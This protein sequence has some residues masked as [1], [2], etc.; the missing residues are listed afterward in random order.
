ME[1]TQ[2]E[3]GQIKKDRRQTS[4]LLHLVSK[5]LS[6]IKFYPWLTKYARLYSSRR[7]ARAV[8]HSHARRVALL[9]QADTP[10]L[11][12]KAHELADRL[13]PAYHSVVV[14]SHLA[15]ED[16]AIVPGQLTR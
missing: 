12:A 10:G 16:S 8:I 5:F 1:D 3:R 15:A 11:R 7:M 6:L 4:A 9:N 13:F 2:A 14:A